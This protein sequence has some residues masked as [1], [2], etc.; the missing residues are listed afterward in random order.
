MKAFF[1]YIPEGDLI[2]RMKS[3]VNIAKIIVKFFLL[4]ELS[5]LFKSGEITI[6]ATY[7][8]TNQYLKAFMFKC[9]PY[10]R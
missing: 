9:E 7:G 2:G 10:G 4:T 3:K 5:P 6:K 8:G 1:P